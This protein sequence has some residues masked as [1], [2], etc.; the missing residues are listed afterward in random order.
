MFIKVIKNN[1]LVVLIAGVSA[2]LFFKSGSWGVSET[3]E[4]RYAE[5]SREMALSGNWL[6]P[7]LL[8]IGHYHKPPLTYII[9]VFSYKLWGVNPFAVRFFLQ[10]AA[11]FQMVLVYGIGMILFKDKRTALL[12]A[13]IY[14]SLPAV[15]IST[16]ALTTDAFLATFAL[17][18][19]FSWMKYRT[20]GQLPFLYGFYGFL[21]LGFLT[22]G[23]L[24]FVVPVVVVCGFNQYYSGKTGNTRHH[25]I[26][27]I[28]S[29]LLGF[30]WF[31]K[32]TLDNPQFI[33]YFLV[34][35]LYERLT[36]P[37]A[38]NRSQPFWYYL[39]IAPSISF[40]WFFLVTM[41]FIKCGSLRIKA[42][43]I[44]K[45]LFLWVFPALIFFSFSSSKLILYILPIFP[46]IALASAYF[47]T[48][49]N[50]K[51]LKVLLRVQ[52]IY[53]TFAIAALI[54]LPPFFLNIPWIW[55]VVWLSAMLLICLVII[56]STGRISTPSKITV[57][58]LV[59]TLSLMVIATFIFS[60][61]PASINSTQHLAAFIKE[62]K[63]DNRPILIY[64]TRLPS[65]AFHLNKDII[66]I[67]DN[68][69]S[70]KRETQFE[71]DENWRNL[72]LNLNTRQDV[73]RLKGYLKKRAVLIVKNDL[74]ENRKWLANN[75]CKTINIDHWKIF[76]NRQYK[77]C[78]L[79]GD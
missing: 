37:A 67:A 74:P 71:L 23:P 16:R 33:D 2:M 11:I 4:A 76:Y 40:P 70:L 35:H 20:Q 75:Y 18:A 38:F 77:P 56:S 47:L 79:A 53:H 49:I 15:L 30:S 62:N 13:I 73:D 27:I 26:A 59:F 57:S 21:A 5:I 78:A 36:D 22:K 68:H 3:S 9:T 14:I 69:P 50:L 41:Q 45:V 60:A 32:L 12:S 52:L 42:S 17:L 64:N 7:K 54:L 65:I 24:I 1:A 58:A 31:I 34:R 48:K 28:G 6:H 29:T 8:G 39:L 51:T 66:S 61:N 43:P 63:L 10:L 25:F 55:E 46:G 19:I 44:Q 72:L